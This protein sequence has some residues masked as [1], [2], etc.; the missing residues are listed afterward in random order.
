MSLLWVSDPTFA[1]QK[2]VS[3]YYEHKLR[4]IIKKKVANLIDKET[5][6]FP[7]MQEA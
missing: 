3:K 4:F 1:G 5:I 2:Q 7:I 6:R